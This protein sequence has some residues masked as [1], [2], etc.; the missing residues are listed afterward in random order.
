MRWR[1]GTSWGPAPAPGRRARGSVL[2]IVLWIAF[3]LVSLALYFA[4]TMSF[5]LRAADQRAAATEA[6]QAIAGAIRY[7]SNVLATLVE[8][9]GRLPDDFSYASEAVPVGDA[10][11]WFLGRNPQQALASQPA[12]GLVDEASKLNLNTATAE[13]L[14][15]LPGMTAEFAAAIVDW[16]DSD[17]EPGPGGAEDEIYL[18]L[19][20]AYR[21]KN[22]PFES[23]E[24]L[25]LV[26][27]ADLRYLFGEDANLNGV[28]DPNEND[29]DASPPD[30]DRDGQLDAGLLEY[31]T[32]HSAEP[33]TRADGSARINVN[34]TNQQT[35]AG[36]LQQYFGTDRAN[37]ILRQLGTP[38][39][40][41]GG[42][43]GPGGGGPGGGTN[44]TAQT[45]T[46]L[47]HFYIRSGM[48]PDEFAQ[49]EGELTAST[50]ATVT[51]LVNVNTASEAV[52]ACIPGIGFENAG[53][54][55]AYRQMQS[56]QLAT[57]AWVTEVLEEADALLAGPYLTGRS[58]QYSA[59]IV[60]LGRQGRGYQRVRAVF[61]TSGAAPR[62]VARQDLTHLGWALGRDVRDLLL[63]ARREG[64]SLTGTR[65]ATGLWT[66]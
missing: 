40:G 2:I 29:G 3:G 65:R 36:L 19:T 63:T 44:A 8:E 26:Y 15:S 47:L 27:G 20:P 7:A 34:S 53:A 66:W 14:Q 18:R 32:V 41:G 54:L 51:G 42:G 38:G 31:V 30:D 24:E 45:F 4:Q 5:E 10:T 37:A 62:L 43:G 52:L 55:V 21:C 1:P 13:M 57:L 16:R 56:G 11:F 22:A 49:V 61:D 17:S 12:F 9:P 25:R 35:L 48:T 33:G 50:N 46:S 60:A 6:S 23:V 58:Y 59:D 64:V 39:G 28:L